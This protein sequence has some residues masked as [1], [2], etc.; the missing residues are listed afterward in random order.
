MGK[1]SPLWT[2]IITGIFVILMIFAIP[3]E[4]S[5]KKDSIQW[6]GFIGKISRDIAYNMTVL[7]DGIVVVGWTSS[8]KEYGDQNALVIKLSKDGKLLWQKELGGSGTDGAICVK[9]TKDGGFVVTI[10]SDSQDGDFPS[11]FGGQDI[12]LLKYNG[13]GNLEW[14]KCY[15]T[16]GYETA[17]DVIEDD[18]YVLAGYTTVNGSED[19]WV[20][21]TDYQ[22]NVL[23]D[24][25]FGGSDW[26][27]AFGLTKLQD[28]YVVVGM[29]KSHD[30]DIFNNG[31]SDMW[32]VRISRM[33][34]LLWQKTVG[35][36]DWDQATNIISTKDG[37]FAVCGVSW[38]KEI[39][40]ESRMGDFVLTK[41]DI[42]GNQ[43]FLKTYG[44]SSD[45]I[46]Q[47]LIE[48][49]DGY[50]LIGTTW[51][52]DGDIVQK[53]R[54]SDYWLI[55]TDKKGN[56]VWQKCLG[57]DMDEI[58]YALQVSGDGY[59]VAGVSYSYVAGLR[60][61]SH[62]GGDILLVKVR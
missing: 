49:D 1:V 32:F 45:D 60:A 47:K 16:K 58:A 29:T 25:T 54:G 35:G 61:R 9:A 18:G 26:D 11:Q 8:L 36:S 38:S 12:W 34:E 23:W 55:K 42:D 59:L 31:S 17:F 37:G 39:T 20:I 2:A 51:S 46:A 28:G 24:K 52:D 62:G 57:D 5:T 13:E 41:F 3:Y 50:V 27:T 22:G 14:K 7:S 30:R 6:L 4:R 43:E 53:H 15:G 10:I 56:L 21:K 48:T 44:G 33:G 40:G 19:F